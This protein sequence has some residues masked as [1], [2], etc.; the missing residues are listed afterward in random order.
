MVKCKEGK[1]C[2]NCHTIQPFSKTHVTCLND[3]SKSCGCLKSVNCGGCKHWSGD[4]K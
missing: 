1:R 2:G 3:Q 4:S